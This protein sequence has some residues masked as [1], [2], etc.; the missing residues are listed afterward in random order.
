VAGGLSRCERRD[1]SA[2][3]G[4]GRRLKIFFLL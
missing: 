4:G 1:F 2:A 3:V